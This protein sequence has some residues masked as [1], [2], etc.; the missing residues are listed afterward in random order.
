MTADTYTQL[1]GVLYYRGSIASPQADSILRNLSH[2]IQA[3]GERLGLSGSYLYFITSCPTRVNDGVCKLSTEDSF[4]LGCSEEDERTNS[5]HT[6]KLK[7]THTEKINA[8]VNNEGYFSP[9]SIIIIA[10]LAGFL[11]ISTG[12]C[13]YCYRRSR[14]T[15]S[16]DTQGRGSSKAKFFPRCRT[17]STDANEGQESIKESTASIRY[18]WSL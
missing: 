6:D 12:L 7:A 15:S 17:T 2:Y 14:A 1:G 11:I 8:T 5:P 3:G 13:V 16:K 18:T 9:L 10:V 4:A